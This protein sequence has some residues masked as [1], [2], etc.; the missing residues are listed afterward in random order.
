MKVTILSYGGIIQSIEFPDRKGEPGNVVL[1]FKTLQE[2]VTYNPAPTPG[3]PAGTGAYFG[4]LI[5]RCTEPHRWWPLQPR[6][7]RPL[8][9]A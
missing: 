3:N 5:G 8:R 7:Y 2:Y 6:R 1:G 9:A 4:A